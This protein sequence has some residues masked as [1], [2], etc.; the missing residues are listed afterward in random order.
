MDIIRDEFKHALDFALKHPGGSN[1]ARLLDDHRHGNSFVQQTKLSFGGF[2]IRGVQVDTTVE[3]RAV[4]IGHHGS[5]V[6]SRVG[7][8]G[9]LELCTGL[10]D[11]LIPVGRVSF[12]AGVDRLA[13]AG[14]KHH[15]LTSVDEFSNGAVEAES[16]H[17]AALERKDQLDGRTVGHVT[18]ADAVGTRPK[19]ILRRTVAARLLLVDRKDS[20][21]TDV[22]VNVAGSIQGI[23]GHAEFPLFAGRDN[24]G[25]FI[26]FRDKDRADSTVDQSVD[27]H[28][29]R[30]DIQLLLVVA[31]TVDLTRQTVQLGNSRTL[32]GGRDELARR[33]NGIEQNHQ[34]VIMRAGHD[35]TAERFG[36]LCVL[37]ASRQ[38]IVSTTSQGT[39]DQLQKPSSADALLDAQPVSDL[40]IQAPCQRTESKSKLSVMVVSELF[41]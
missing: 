13:T 22:T 11:G 37:E 6:A 23:K 8:L 12:V 16:V 7:L 18:G 34:I 1:S 36:I 28:V 5:N 32:H 29:V 9:V 17:V 38:A 24:N 4:D 30:Q 14:R 26:L 31:R 33:R 21:H 20:T 40:S 39:S 25:I 19:E 27:H 2:G 3:D 15:L 10:L 35:K 41:C